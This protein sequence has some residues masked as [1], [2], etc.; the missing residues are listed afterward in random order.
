MQMTLPRRD[1]L[2][3][4]LVG[5]AGLVYVL[6]LAGV[7]PGVRLVTGIVLAMGFAASAAAVVPGFTDLLHSSKTY[8]AITS[9]LGLL[10]LVAGV[11]ALATGSTAMLATLVVTTVVLWALATLHHRRKR[12]R[13]DATSPAKPPT[14]AEPSSQGPR[15]WAARRI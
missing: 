8:L 15:P 1:L 11:I 5:V 6:W 12:S 7:G 14:D 13:P 3:T 2:A 9:A 10:A 4:V